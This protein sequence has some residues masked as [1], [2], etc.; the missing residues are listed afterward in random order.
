VD[1]L[2]NMLPQQVSFILLQDKPKYLHTSWTL[3]LCWP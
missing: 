2:R 1:G 3:Q